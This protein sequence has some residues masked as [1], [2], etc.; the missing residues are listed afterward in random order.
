MKR[1]A[2]R[3][4]P[5]LV[6]EMHSDPAAPSPPAQEPPA[7]HRFG[8]G[9]R[10]L[11]ADYV[12]AQGSA[13]VEE[14]AACFGVSTVTVRADLNAL[15]AGGW[16]ERT[17]GG[18]L[19]AQDAD[20]PSVPPFAQRVGHRHAEKVRIA[21]LAA[22][23]I[24]DGDTVLL[25]SGTTT[26]ELA[27]QIRHLPLRALTVVSNAIDVAA[28]LAD[29]AHV[30]VVMPGGV[31]QALSR[32]LVGPGAEAALARIRADLCFLGADGFDTV[33][34]IT[35]SDPLEARLNQCMLDAAERRIAL[36][37]ASKLGRRN[38]ARIAPLS[39]LSC[40]VTDTGA[41]APIVTA[42]REAGLDV[43]LA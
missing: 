5:S 39:A 19:M 27:R 21:A 25:D 36:V 13:T 26:V 14:L 2:Q 32:S 28:E 6:T 30:R 33:A 31:L 20:A 42:C 10:R 22:R 7:R 1:P 35:T 17:H 24:G 3:K 8:Q 38:V 15:A 12:K 9:R 23:M 29:V 11:I 43:Q 40:L 41:P 4:I 34:G 16:L 37:D 18:A